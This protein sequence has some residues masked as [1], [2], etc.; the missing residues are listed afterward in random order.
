MGKHFQE[1]SLLIQTLKNFPDIILEFMKNEENLITCSLG[2]LLL[3][4]ESWSY[5]FIKGDNDR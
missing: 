5:F 4:L 2:R 1:L 3:N